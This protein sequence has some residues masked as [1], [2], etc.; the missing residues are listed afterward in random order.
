MD[1]AEKYQ[2]CGG[3]SCAVNGC[4]NNPRKLN[5][6]PYKYSDLVKMGKP[7]TILTASN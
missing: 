6:W 5:L 4:S 2:K 7:V 3:T 1:I